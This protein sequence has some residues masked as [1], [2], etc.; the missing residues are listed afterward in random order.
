MKLHNL[1]FIYLLV[2]S[3]TGLNAQL[4][5]IS[6]GNVG[7]GDN[8]MTPNSSLELKN[9]GW[10]RFNAP[11]GQSGI[12]FYKSGS[13]TPTDIQ[14]GGKIFY[15]GSNDLLRIGTMQNNSYRQAINIRRSDGNIGIKGSA[16]SAY[17]L[18][19]HGNASFENDV[20]LMG[21][22]GI[23]G[24][25][26]GNR[27]KV[28]GNTNIVGQL[29]SQSISTGSLT[30][31]GLT[32]NGNLTVGNDLFVENT[33][34][35][36]Y[37]HLWGGSPDNYAPLARIYGQ[38]Q[39]YHL[40]VMGKTYSSLGYFQSDLNSKKHVTSIDGEQMLSKLMKLSGHKY[41]FKTASELEPLYND[42]TF[43]SINDTMMVIPDLPE[44]QHYGLLAQ[45]VEKDFPEL[46]FRDPA[47]NIM[48]INY[49]GMIPVLLEALKEQQRILTS[50]E[51]RFVSLES[52]LEIKSI[53]NE[54]KSFNIQDET[55]SADDDILQYTMLYQN[56]PNPF[57]Q[58]TTIRF[59]IPEK[60]NQAMLYIYNMQGMQVQSH[61]ISDR[62]HSAL[63]IQGAVLKPGMYLYTLIT[64]GRAI[65]TKRMILTD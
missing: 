44:G 52:K 63:E 50:Y 41:E 14:Y 40:Y 28:N 32:S 1:F 39:G 21:D 31:G 62:G 59:V 49:S 18:R 10:L 37:F 29:T 38:T 36:D 23:G 4:R 61:K 54:L 43:T 26:D 13:S 27:L 51:D 53:E 60:V 35:T 30:S 8:L 42:G 12:L 48:A 6:N 11:S 15:D 25:A 64:D 46:V 16:S 2:I 9:N 55:A 56:S 47:T 57:N 34:Y 22:V 24:S 45:E 65:D 33:M 5:V 7:V 3:T 58:V 19:V 20:F 17:S